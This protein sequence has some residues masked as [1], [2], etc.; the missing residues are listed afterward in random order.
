MNLEK[1]IVK[2]I[3]ESMDD[4]WHPYNIIYPYPNDEVYMQSTREMKQTSGYSRPQKSKRV[5]VFLGIK[6]QRISW[7]KILNRLRV[8]GIICH[9]PEDL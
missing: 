2:L 5:S 1:G 4:L 3:S 6:V 7:G 9:A 8:Y